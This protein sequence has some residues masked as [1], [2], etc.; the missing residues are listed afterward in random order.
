[1]ILHDAVVGDRAFIESASFVLDEFGPTLDERFTTF[2]E[3][4]NRVRTEPD[5]SKWE[6]W[7][8]RADRMELAPLPDGTLRRRALRH[9]LAAEWASVAQRD[10]LVALSHVTAPVLVVHADAAWFDSPYLDEA[11]VQSQLAAARDSRLYVAHGQHHVDVLIKP[12]SGLVTA[13]R[14]FAQEIRAST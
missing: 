11:T 10:A 4:H 9:A 13:M 6:H 12:S 1:L 2:Y 5:D 8:E 14:A 7:L 3:Y